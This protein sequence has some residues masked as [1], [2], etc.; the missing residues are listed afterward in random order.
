[1]LT[2]KR[3]SLTR[4]FTH[5]SNQFFWSQKFRKYVTH[6]ANLYAENV[7]NFMYSPEMQQKKKKSKK[8]FVSWIIAF[9]LVAL[10]SVCYDQ[11]TCHQ[12]SMC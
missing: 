12:Q 4:P 7:Q 8:V 10:N 3:C 1:M 9:E 11:N 2:I 6:E 5:L